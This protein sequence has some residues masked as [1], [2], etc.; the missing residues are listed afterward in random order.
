MHQ[1]RVPR[2][3]GRASKPPPEL[4]EVLCGTEPQR[5]RRDVQRRYVL[6]SVTDTIEGGAVV[7]VS[8]GA[9]RD[10]AL[11]SGTLS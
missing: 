4:C 2:A 10:G 3:A 5:E 1:V 11:H 7:Q 9:D 6:A 8:E